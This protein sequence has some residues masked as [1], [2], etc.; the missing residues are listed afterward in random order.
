[1]AHISWNVCTPL[2][3][4]LKYDIYNREMDS[5]TMEDF[6]ELVFERTPRVRDLI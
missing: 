5:M 6:D 1:M 4:A 2:S 3:D